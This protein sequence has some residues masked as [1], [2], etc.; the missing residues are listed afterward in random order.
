MQTT[1]SR[2]L[3]A[4]AIMTAASATVLPAMAAPMLGV[5]RPIATTSLIE[6]AQVGIYFGFGDPYYRPYR[7]Y[8]RPYYGYRR[9][10]DSP[11]PVTYY[12]TRPYV[13]RPA[14]APYGDPDAIAR[15]ASQFRSF[16]AN[17]GTYIT[18]EGEERLCPYLR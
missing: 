2:T 5:E 9:Y 10:Y 14:P 17:T 18:Y 12:E 8:Y 6:K 16:N 3:R 13:A 4:L 7:P 1:S 15:C 11:P